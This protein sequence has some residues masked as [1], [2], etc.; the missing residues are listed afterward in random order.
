MNTER[1]F[2]SAAIGAGGAGDKSFI[3]LWNPANSGKSVKI[4]AVKINTK[5]TT[6]SF[7]THTAQQGSAGTIGKIANKNIGGNASVCSLYGHDLLAASVAG[8]VLIDFITTAD[9]ALPEDLSDAPFIV[10]PGQSFFILNNTVNSAINMVHM[11]WH[12]IDNKY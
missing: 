9:T 7:M 8:T 6:V 2:S 10:K 5:D 1:F 3:E 11:A 12:E 4:T